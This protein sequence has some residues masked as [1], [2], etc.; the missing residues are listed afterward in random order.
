MSQTETE[1]LYCEY[2]NQQE[3]NRLNLYAL[4]APNSKE[5]LKPTDIL[6][7]DWDKYKSNQPITQDIKE[8]LD[9]MKE[10]YINK[11]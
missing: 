7:F 2:I 5:K 4:I 10:K 6:H 8:Q 9:K 1:L 11:I 3:L